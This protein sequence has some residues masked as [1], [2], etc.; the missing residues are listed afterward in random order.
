[1][2]EFLTNVQVLRAGTGQ[3]LGRAKLMGKIVTKL[4]RE[5]FLEVPGKILLEV[6]TNPRMQ[7]C[8]RPFTIRP[9]EQTP[10]SGV[11]CSTCHGEPSSRRGGSALSG[12]RAR[13]VG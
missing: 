12:C 3:E 2:G 11:V 5:G 8:L 6:A 4:K 10:T 13:V 1:M 7:S 9:T